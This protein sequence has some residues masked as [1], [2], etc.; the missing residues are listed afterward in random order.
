MVARARDATSIVR[1]SLVHAEPVRCADLLAEGT[2]PPSTIDVEAL[3]AERVV[4]V[5]PDAVVAID[6]A[7][8]SVAWR[9]DGVAD[10]VDAQAFVVRSDPPWIG[11]AWWLESSRVGRITG[12]SA[13]GD[14]T[15]TWDLPVPIVGVSAHADPRYA[16][17]SSWDR[18]L[19][20]VFAPF[21]R[22]VVDDVSL[23]PMY[24]PHVIAG[25]PPRIAGGG[26]TGGIRMGTLDDPSNVI[27][28]VI[29]GCDPREAAPR[30]GH[31]DEVIVRCGEPSVASLANVAT[32]ETRV[33]LG[34]GPAAPE[35]DVRGLGIFE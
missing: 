2:L 15:R 25:E 30:P 7:T 1:F 13:S 19:L 17:A 31:V 29:D 4:A 8:D 34:P 28:R 27:V 14:D 35:L 16:Y 21:S 32:G 11:V 22:T 33:L 10:A 23:R 9:V 3:S 20:H 24:K 5:G 18:N 6:V 26:R 12:T